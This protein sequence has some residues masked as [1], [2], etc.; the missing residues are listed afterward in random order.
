MLFSSLCLGVDGN[1]EIQK[2][3]YKSVIFLKLTSYHVFPK[4]R[5]SFRFGLNLDK[6][7]QDRLGFF[8]QWLSIAQFIN[9]CLKHKQNVGG[10]QPLSGNR[11]RLIYPSTST[12]YLVPGTRSLVQSEYSIH[13]IL[14]PLRLLLLLINIIHTAHNYICI[15]HNYITT[16]RLPVGTGSSSTTYWYWYSYLLAMHMV[17]AVPPPAGQNCSCSFLLVPV[18]I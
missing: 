3:T 10:V 17:A 14:S 15:S 5:T 8:L 7:T 13:M 12:R 9:E 1:S 16:G 18:S 4:M 6:K 11:S 2:V